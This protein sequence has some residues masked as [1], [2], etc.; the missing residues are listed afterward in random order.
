MVMLTVRSSP[1]DVHRALR[2]WAAQHGRSTEAEVHEILTVAIRPEPPVRPP[3][4]PVRVGPDDPS[5]KHDF[6][7]LN[8]LNPHK[9][10]DE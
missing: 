5:D 7:V 9:S 4:C 6:E 1:D 10:P 2:V 3:G 8:P